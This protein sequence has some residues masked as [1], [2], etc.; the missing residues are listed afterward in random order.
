M[1]WWLR[2]E[3]ARLERGSSRRLT[4]MRRRPAYIR[5]IN[6]RRRLFARGLPRRSVAQLGGD[7]ETANHGQGLTGPCHIRSVS[8]KRP[9]QSDRGPQKS[10]SDFWGGLAAGVRACVRREKVGTTKARGGRIPRPTSGASGHLKADPNVRV[11]CA[12]EGTP[13]RRGVGELEV[14]LPLFASELY[15]WTRSR[16]RSLCAQ[17]SRCSGPLPV[18]LLYLVGAH[19]AGPGKRNRAPPLVGAVRAFPAPVRGGGQRGHRTHRRAGGSGCSPLT[20]RS[21]LRRP[22]ARTP[23][24]GSLAAGSSPSAC[25]TAS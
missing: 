15:G 6:R 9:R 20:L 16:G 5:V 4:V 19:E 11:Q 22:S 7:H 1:R 12:S 10:R 24:A 21:A 13:S 3:R 2:P 25:P 23:R 14:L 17:P 18:H 8:R